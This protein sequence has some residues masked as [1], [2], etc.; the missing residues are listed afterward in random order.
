MAVWDK[1]RA[2]SSVADEHSPHRKF[3]SD[4]KSMLMSMADPP[5]PSP[6]LVQ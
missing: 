3:T 4:E 6:Y 1:V 2:D 5:W